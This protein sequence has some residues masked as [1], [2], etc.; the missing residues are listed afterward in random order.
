MIVR[1]AKQN[2]IRVEGAGSTAEIGITLEKSFIEAYKN[3]V[4]IDVALTVDRADARPHPAVFDGD[5]HLAGRAPGIGLPVVAEIQNAAGQSDALDRVRR[6]EGS[7]RPLRI[8]GAW[9]IWSE[10]VGGADEIQGKG[11]ASTP[12]TNPDHVF[13]IHPV[14]RV[15]GI[16]LLETLHPVE[17]YRPGS[18]DLIFRSLETIPCR[19]LPGATTTTIVTPK[20]QFNDVEFLLEVG[21]ERPQVVADGRFLNAAALDLKGDRLVP[22]VRMAFVRNSPPEKIVRSLRPGSR[23]HVFGL[24]RI[25]LAEA[26]S[27]AA[28]SGDRPELLTRSLPYEILIIGVFKDP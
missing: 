6:V 13:E 22:R 27:R 15:A 12:G 21:P 16:G 3:R 25:G 23:L 5:F 11:S 10:H 14:T 2:L 1:E 28:R 24:P 17:G 4:T 7:G 9:R 20:R 19:I 8:T 26:A 18:A